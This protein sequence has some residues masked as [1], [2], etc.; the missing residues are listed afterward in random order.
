VTVAAATEASGGNAIVGHAIEG[1]RQRRRTRLP[2]DLHPP[3]CERFMYVLNRRHYGYSY[4][5]WHLSPFNSAGSSTDHVSSSV[6]ETAR[7]TLEAQ[8]TGPEI[9]A[10]AHDGTAYVDFFR[11]LLARVSASTGA[12]SAAAICAHKV[13]AGDA[14]Q[15]S[16][17]MSV[18]DHIASLLA[19][20]VALQPLAMPPFTAEQKVEMQIRNVDEQGN[21][22]GP[23]VGRHLLATAAEVVVDAPGVDDRETNSSGI[24]DENRPAPQVT[25]ELQVSQERVNVKITDQYHQDGADDGRQRTGTSDVSSDSSAAQMLTAALKSA[26]TAETSLLFF[27][28]GAGDYKTCEE[29]IAELY[30]LLLVKQSAEIEGNIDSGQSTYAASDAAVSRVVLEAAK[31]IQPGSDIKE[32]QQGAIAF[33]SAL[34]LLANLGFMLEAAAWV[35]DLDCNESPYHALHGGGSAATPEYEAAIGE[36][37]ER[38]SRQERCYRYVVVM[39]RPRAS[40]EFDEQ[41]TAEWIQRY[42]AQLSRL[43]LPTDTC[44]SRRDPNSQ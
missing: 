44:L 16:P 17:E 32:N 38:A 1:G 7:A 9:L 41:K 33:R 43:R 3:D 5:D 31:V 8:M 24:R 25:M 13:D 11:G 28:N 20:S 12:S 26:A 39:Q 42:K 2:P 10:R 37:R 18:V 6:I 34:Q 22:I 15:S 23:L 27:D 4:A 19:D 35:E 29:A 36:A 21:H 30:E 14:A 40:K